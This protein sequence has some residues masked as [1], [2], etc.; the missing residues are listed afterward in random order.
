MQPM[1]V[2]GTRKPEEEMERPSGLARARV[3]GTSRKGKNKIA[4]ARQSQP[5]WDGETWIVIQEIGRVLFSSEPGPWLE[6]MPAVDPSLRDKL[7]RWVH[8]TAGTDF[9]LEFMA[10]GGEA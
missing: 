2:A 1:K 6:I 7:S 5:G 4:E 3:T 10:N 8:G 9:R